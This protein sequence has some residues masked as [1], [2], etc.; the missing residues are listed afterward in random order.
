M[1]IRA[2]QTYTTDGKVG[3]TIFIKSHMKRGTLVRV[4]LPN[5]EEV[6]VTVR[7]IY[8]ALNEVIPS[9]F[10]KRHIGDYKE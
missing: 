1:T 2:L 9:N 7:D 5:G 3:E 8:T 6:D 10:R 4:V